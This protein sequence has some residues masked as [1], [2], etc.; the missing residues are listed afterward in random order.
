MSNLQSASLLA[1]LLQLIGTQS[2]AEGHYQDL[3]AAIRRFVQA[4]R[5]RVNEACPQA[6]SVFWTAA[7]SEARRRFGLDGKAEN[8]IQSLCW[9][10]EPK[11][12]RR[13][14]LPA[15]SKESL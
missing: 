15:Q 6:G 2:P 1:L 5:F 3:G 13:S 12:R 11:R 8:L 10:A 4:A 7:A 14:A 9:R